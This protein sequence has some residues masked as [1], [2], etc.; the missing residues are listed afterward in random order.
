MGEDSNKT[1]EV[2]DIIVMSALLVI[3]SG[4]VAIFRWAIYGE[5]TTSIE[6]F[7]KI[8]T[9]SSTPTPSEILGAYA[10]L[11]GLAAALHLLII[12]GLILIGISFHVTTGKSSGVNFAAVA[13]ALVEEVVFRGIPLIIALILGFDPVLL[14]GIGTGAWV[15]YHDVDEWAYAVPYALLFAQLWAVG[16]WEWAILLHVI[17][18]ATLAIIVSGLAKIEN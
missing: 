2:A 9:I 4:G 15:M 17:H 13:F 5:V 18:N 12:G 10:G 14:I 8:I 6:E 11:G 16:F 3:L 7:V 1:L